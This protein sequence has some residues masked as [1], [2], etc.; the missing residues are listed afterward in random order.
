M[1][2]DEILCWHYNQDKNEKKKNKK[3]HET[4]MSDKQADR[5][6]SNLE[7]KSISGNKSSSMNNKKQQ[8]L[9]ITCV[10]LFNSLLF[11]V[12]DYVL[13]R[14]DT[15]VL[16]QCIIVWSVLLR[17][18]ILGVLTQRERRSRLGRDPNML[19]HSRQTVQLSSCTKAGCAAFSL[20]ARVLTCVNH[21]LF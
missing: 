21:P 11:Q 6:F 18:W 2:L 9:N 5:H 3:H 12:A 8:H 7:K 4:E 1:Q 17:A 20:Y 14:S 16:Q 19:L 10:V 15:E 13:L